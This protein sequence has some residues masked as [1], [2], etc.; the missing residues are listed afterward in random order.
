MPA[1]NHPR[2]GNAG[3]GRRKNLGLTGFTLIGGLGVQLRG[4]FP[5]WVRLGGDRVLGFRPGRVNRG[6]LFFDSP[7][8][9]R[10][11]IHVRIG[12]ENATWTEPPPS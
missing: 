6:I 7:P 1:S 2:A 8:H 9:T 4:L 5:G 3:Q 10:A 11:E 12:G